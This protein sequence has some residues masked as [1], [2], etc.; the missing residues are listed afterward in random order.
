MTYVADNNKLK[1]ELSAIEFLATRCRPAPEL[2][3]IVNLYWDEINGAKYGIRYFL[4]KVMNKLPSFL[5]QHLELPMASQVVHEFEER[6]FL[7]GA[8]QDGRACIFNSDA[9]PHNLLD[10]Q[11]THLVFAIG[12]RWYVIVQTERVPVETPPYTAEV[13]SIASMFQNG[14]AFV[15]PISIGAHYYHYY[16]GKWIDTATGVLPLDQYPVTYDANLKGKGCLYWDG[17]KPYDPIS[18]LELRTKP[19]GGS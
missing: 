16:C 17:S 13:P 10:Q 2:Q 6:G 14:E 19:V 11:V 9:D 1:V 15:R 7:R 8:D 12:E 5:Q 4:A 3:Q 18:G